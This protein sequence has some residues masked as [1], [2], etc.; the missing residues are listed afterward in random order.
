MVGTYG[1]E[2]GPHATCVIAAQEDN[3]FRKEMLKGKVMTARKKGMHL[4]VPAVMAIG[5]V[6]STPALAKCSPRWR[7]C[8]GP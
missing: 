5:L 6:A 1:H 8:T 3:A 4:I 7:Y 2:N